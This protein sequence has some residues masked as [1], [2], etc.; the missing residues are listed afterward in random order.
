MLY[1]FADRCVR[2]VEQTSSRLLLELDHLNQT[3]SVQ[4]NVQ[5][6]TKMDHMTTKTLKLRLLLQASS[7]YV[8]FTVLLRIVFFMYPSSR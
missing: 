5:G 8:A 6:W 3:N 7:K 4:Y 2:K 1:F